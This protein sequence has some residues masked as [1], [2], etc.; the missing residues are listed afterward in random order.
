M[1]Q[2]V[3]LPGSSF[4]GFRYCCTVV[5]GLACFVSRFDAVAV[6]LDCRLAV[7]THKM[8]VY[9]WSRRLLVP[10]QLPVTLL[11]CAVAW[12]VTSNNKPT[13]QLTGMEWGS[14]TGEDERE[15]SSACSLAGNY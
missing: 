4:G 14:R 13:N 12:R 11:G 5:P 15:S 9:T 10:R 6:L 7:S 2:M 8:T 3:V 1:D